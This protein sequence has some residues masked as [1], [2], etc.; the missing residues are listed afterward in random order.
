MQHYHHLGSSE[1]KAFPQVV[2]ILEIIQKLFACVLVCA[3]QTRGK[4]H[5]Q[6]DHNTFLISSFPQKGGYRE[7]GVSKWRPFTSERIL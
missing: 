4:S 7:E 2:Q 3:W 5:L 1:A 6:N